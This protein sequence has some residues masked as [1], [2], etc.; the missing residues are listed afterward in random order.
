M[1]ERF[2]AQVLNNYIGEYVENFNPQNLS[3]GIVQGRFLTRYMPYL[4][5]CKILLEIFGR[6][7]G[8]LHLTVHRSLK[9][10]Y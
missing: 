8:G 3:I 5:D 6:H 4:S 10:F 1:L 9:F 2:A 7:F